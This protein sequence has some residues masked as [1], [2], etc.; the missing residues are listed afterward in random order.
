MSR[1][2][3]TVKAYFSEFWIFLPILEKILKRDSE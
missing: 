3:S 1:K 2:I